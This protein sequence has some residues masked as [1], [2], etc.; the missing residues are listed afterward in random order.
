[1]LATIQKWTFKTT[2]KEEKS[3][4]KINFRAIYFKGNVNT[5][6]RNIW[7]HNPCYGKYFLQPV[8]QIFVWFFETQVVLVPIEILSPLPGRLCRWHSSDCCV[9]HLSRLP[10]HER[11]I[12]LLFE[13][14]R[15]VSWLF[16]F[17]SLCFRD[18]RMSG[19]TSRVRM[20][21]SEPGMGSRT[22]FAVGND[23]TRRLEHWFL[24]L[25]FAHLSLILVIMYISGSQRCFQASTSHC[26]HETQCYGPRSVPLSSGSTHY[27][28]RI[29]R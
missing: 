13:H 8:C 26:T 19:T 4:T 27:R 6:Y 3:I 20:R 21:S 16:H 28:R 5:P 24:Q 11:S 25:K 7:N 2:I 12:S 9:S 22:I 10:P 23:A 15:S 14:G 1:M 18:S 29:I 17:S